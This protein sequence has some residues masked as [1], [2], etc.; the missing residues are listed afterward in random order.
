MASPKADLKEHLEIHAT[1]R[2][3]PVL[4]QARMTVSGFVP[5]DARSAASASGA[6]RPRFNDD[7]PGRVAADSS[8]DSLK[9][10][11]QFKTTQGARQRCAARY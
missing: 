9:R 4:K 7:V 1:W 2:I 6:S 10:S 11:P 8:L 5:I 3:I